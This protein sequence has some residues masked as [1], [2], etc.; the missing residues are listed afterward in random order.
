MAKSTRPSAGLIV[1]SIALVAA[2]AGTAAALPGKNKIDK[3]DLGKNV[4]RAK[5][6]KKNAVTTRKIKAEAVTGAKVNEASLGQVPSAADAA[7]VAGVRAVKINVSLADGASQ[8]LVA[9][10]PFTLTATCQMDNSTDEI[11]LEISTTQS[12]G[13]LVA[14]E[15]EADFDPE[16]SP[17]LW[18]VARVQAGSPATGFGGETQVDTIDPNHPVAM[19]TDGSFIAAYTDLIVGAN[20]WGAQDR[21]QVRGYLHVGDVT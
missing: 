18:E 11:E 21:C 17:L 4:V 1:A 7:A 5:N 9:H 8:A 13:V 15:R 10:G 20:L 14:Y 19:A 16:D 2:L 6:L 3:N 12:D